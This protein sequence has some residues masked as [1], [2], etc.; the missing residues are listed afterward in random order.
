MVGKDRR[1][2]CSRNV[3]DANRKIRNLAAY[4]KV[5]PGQK[6]MTKEE[7][8]KGKSPKPKEMKKQ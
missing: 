1:G 3:V 7:K 4:K 2:E 5:Q 6:R 8:S